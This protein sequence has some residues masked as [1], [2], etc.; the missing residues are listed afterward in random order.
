MGQ[1][2]LAVLSLRFGIDRTMQQGVETI[3]WMG[4]YV[5]M[6][7]FCVLNSVFLKQ[8][9][10]IGIFLGFIVPLLI[11]NFI[12]AVFA[13]YS[14]KEMLYPLLLVCLLLQ[15]GTNSVLRAHILIQIGLIF[16]AIGVYFTYI[17]INQ[18]AYQKIDAMGANGLIPPGVTPPIAIA[19]YVPIYVW[20]VANTFA[21]Y[22][23]NV[24]YKV[25]KPT[26]LENKYLKWKIKKG[27][28]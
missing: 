13:W 16:F 22:V 12:L 7:C 20:I 27:N 17:W 23:S 14:P 2:I 25:Q 15:L 28:P 3:L 10:R 19:H 26:W 4:C 6:L 8:G 18:I 24:V 9:F 21:L 5:N 1:A 11:A